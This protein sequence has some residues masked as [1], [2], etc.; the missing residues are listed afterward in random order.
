MGEL[1]AWADSLL[2]A[3]ERFS[4]TP[5]APV[6]DLEWLAAGIHAVK[7]TGL[8]PL[9]EDLCDFARE[10]RGAIP[11]ELLEGA[12]VNADSSFHVHLLRLE[13]FARRI[14]GAPRWTSVV[15]SG[16][17]LTIGHV[18]VKTERDT[19]K[20]PREYALEFEGLLARGYPWIN[21][22]AAGL[23][24][25][26]LIVEVDHAALG[27]LGCRSSVNLSGP[28]VATTRIAG[29]QLRDRLTIV[30]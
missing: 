29:W 5:C 12:P 1:A 3:L 7:S 25:D 2:D 8:N 23:L 16:A 24:G 17:P 20:S 19:F 22:H 27:H 10:V 28:E 14:S 26:S 9:A 11:D 15:V 4:S 13:G 6:L 21:L 30:D 18:M